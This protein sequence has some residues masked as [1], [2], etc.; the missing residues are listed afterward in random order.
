VSATGQIVETKRTLDGRVQSFVCA[1]LLMSPRLAIVRFDH[2]GERRAGGFHFPAGSYTLGF[3]WR[4]RAYN[5]YGIAGPDG[6]VIA[7]RFD[8]VDRVRISSDRVT[9][10]DLLLD[11]WVS[12]S[13][14]VQIEDEDEVH[15]AERDGLLT[16]AMLARIDRTRALLVRDHRRIVAEVERIAGSLVSGGRG[17]D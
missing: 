1:G 6:A 11:L 4:G 12:P 5:C 10:R 16:P 2:G 8:V 7:H 3:F 15:Q 14:D 17:R 13:G 9:Y